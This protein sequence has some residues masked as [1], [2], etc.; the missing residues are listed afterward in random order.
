MLKIQTIIINKKLTDLADTV[1]ELFNMGYT[2]YTTELCSLTK[3]ELQ[4][5]YLHKFNNGIKTCKINPVSKTKMT[6]QELYFKCIIESKCSPNECI[7][8][9]ND[10][11]YLKIAKKTGCNICFS[12]EINMLNILKSIIYYQNENCG[13]LK[14]TMFEKRINIV[15]PMMGKGL[16]LNNSENR[17]D[18]QG[19]EPIDDKV[20]DKA[21]IDVMGKPMIS[22]VIQNL[23]I[24]ANY[25]FII[26]N[27]FSNLD[28]LLISMVP[29]CKIIKCDRK[30]EG[31]VGSILLAEEFINN[32]LPLI[33]ANDN[34]WLD[35]DIEEMMFEFLL[36][37]RQE[38]TLL[39]IVSF[40]SN[41]DNRYNYI[42]VDEDD[43]VIYI[44]QNLPITPLAMTDVYF[45][46]SG[47]DFLRC[48]HKM[49]ST[50]K[51]LEGEFCTM[52][53]TNELLNE[54]N[55]NEISGKIKNV[56]CKY[57]ANIQD[58]NDI[59]QFENYWVS[60][61]KMGFE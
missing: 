14:K 5:F 10:F 43:N 34:Q 22:W 7:I 29:E 32:D 24:D 45:W 6:L 16:R 58:R 9:D 28:K 19:K 20:L 35:W 1:V 39:Q 26:P 38:D 36:N 18:W 50:N 57:F 42:K 25:I 55:N 46:K 53:V 52:F 27:T 15:I 21:L 2:V 31:Q 8:V 44:K 61:V 4:S 47:K 59:N 11:E 51:R 13:I 23:K 3:D 60:N 17:L 37:K 48:S 12:N 41:G 49:T 56:E 30:T 54:I 40:L 33:V